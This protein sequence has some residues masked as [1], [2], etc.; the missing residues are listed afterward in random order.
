MLYRK[1]A[2][3][4]EEHLRSGTDKILLVEGARQTG[5]TFIIRH[6]G[7]KLFPNYIELNFAED[8][9]G[10]RLF[11]NVRTV[12][13]FCFQL[14]TVAGDRMKGRT[15]TL[16]FLDEI[17]EY[18][19]MLTLLKFL[20]E[21]GRFTYIASGSLLGVTL[22]KTTSIPIG[23]VRRIRMAPLDFEEFLLANGFGSAAIDTMREKYLKI[24]S[25][26]EAAHL[27]VM[28]LFK[29]YLLIGGLPEAVNA[30]VESRNI[31]QVRAVQQDVHEY[32][33]EDASKYE[34]ENSKKLKIRR[35]YDMIPSTLENKKKRIRFQEIENKK[36]KRFT[37]YEDEFEYLISAGV[38]LDV[39]AVST[40]VFP[41]AEASNKNLLKLYLNDVGILTGLLYRNNIR[42]VLDDARSVNLGTVYESVVAQELHAHGFALYYYDNRKNGEVDFLI[43]DYDLLSTLPI[44]VKSGKDYTQHSA[45]C[46]FM[47][48]PDYPVKAGVVFSNERTVRTDGRITYLPIYDVMFLSPDS[49]AETAL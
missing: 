1:I 15:D 31:M 9:N 6:I 7:Q 29:K 3:V 20:R 34:R 5:K 22:R 39:K 30:F 44:E 2:S 23:S 24:E 40:P 42:A 48:N 43:D 26:D 36:G 21:D 47:D 13:D 11:E 28:D 45:L 27:R 4:I 12:E 16:V 14:S 19:H 32:Y 37:D 25:L 10:R 46:R 8:K 17:Q 18:E 49:A 35:I 33:A 41:I 38:A